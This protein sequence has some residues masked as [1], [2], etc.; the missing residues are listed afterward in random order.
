LVTS[1]VEHPQ[2]K[3][4]GIRNKNIRIALMVKYIYVI[5]L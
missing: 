2:T 5:C 1:I 4:N 3:N